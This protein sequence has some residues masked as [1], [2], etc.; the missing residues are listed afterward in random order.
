MRQIFNIFFK[1]EDTRPVL[2]LFCLLVGGLAEAIGIGTLLPVTSAVLNPNGTNP[3]VFEQIIRSGFTYVGI[4]PSFTNLMLLI[5]SIMA[6]RSV[7]L[8]SAL[9]YAGITAARVANSFRSRLIRAILEARWSFYA[10]QSGGQVATTLSNDVSRAGDAYMTF[11]TAAAC[12]VQ[13]MAYATIATLINWRVALAGILGGLLVALLSSRLVSISRRSGY[14]Q[15]DRLGTMTTDIV[16]MLHNMKALKS[17][18]RYGPLLLH[19]DHV[20]GR[21]KKS[22]YAASLSRYGLTY[23]NDMLVSMLIGGGAYFAHIKAG[24][25]IPE[26]FVFGVLFFQ[27]VSYASKL[28]KQVQIAA[29]YEGAYVRVSEALERAK[30]EREINTGTLLPDIGKRIAFENVVF[31]HTEQPVL[32][33]LNIEI[34]VNAITVIQGA[35]GAGKTTM[36]DLLVGLLRPQGGVVRV[37]ADDLNDVDAAKWRSMIGYVPQELALFHDTIRANITLYDESVGDAAVEESL[38]L[39]GVSAFVHQLPDGLATDVGEFGGKLSG[40]QRQRISLARA[41]VTNPKLLILDEVTSALDPETEDAIVSN[42]A[43][44]RGRYTI[45]AITHRPAWIRIADRLYTLK[46][47]VAKLQVQSKGKRK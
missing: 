36:L 38:R 43:E 19:M 1:A 14:K 42:I 8:F 32:S 29:Q 23:G 16:E 20:L 41:L 4:D 28:Q 15:S 44:L 34:P 30:A 13:I 46:D 12:W 18:H 6:V 39:S 33:G 31:S 9:S 21:L 10:N 47:G 25:S 27:V 22:L 37:G 7:L 11:A 40:G 24:V 17:M 2:V 45:V 26:L 5:V 35:S 3:S